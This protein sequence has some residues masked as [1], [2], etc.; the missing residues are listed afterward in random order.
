[1]FVPL[2]CVILITQAALQA[3]HRKPLM[4]HWQN[5][6]QENLWFFHSFGITNITNQQYSANILLC[7]VFTA[8]LKK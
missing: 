1:M 2:K 3:G 6:I 8:F 7:E 4:T 5:M